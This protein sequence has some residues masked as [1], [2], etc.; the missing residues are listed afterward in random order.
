MRAA[1]PGPRRAP[2]SGAQAALRARYG[3]RKQHEKRPASQ[4]ET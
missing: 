4:P 2:P 1:A 3:W